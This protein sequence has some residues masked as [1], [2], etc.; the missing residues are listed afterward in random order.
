MLEVSNEILVSQVTLFELAI[1]QTIGKLPELD[2]PLEQV[3]ALIKK[4]NFEI[5]NIH[6][7][8]ISAYCQIPLLNDHR[9]PFDRLILA[10]AFSENIPI[11]SAD[12][13]FTAYESIIHLIAN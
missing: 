10:T 4:D 3:I 8:H 2:V 12:E 11:I 13:K 1:K 7:N 9:D 6:N 5:L